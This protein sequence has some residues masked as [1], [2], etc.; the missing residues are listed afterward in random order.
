M[1]FAFPALT[2]GEPVGCRGEGVG[3]GT[4][5]ATHRHTPLSKLLKPLSA[6]VSPSVKWRL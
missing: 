1:G 4:S 2:P 6:S 5:S 3:S